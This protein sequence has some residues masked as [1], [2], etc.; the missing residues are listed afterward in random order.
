MPFTPYHFGPALL[1]GV[2]LIRFL[3]FSTIM[4]ASVILD[5]EPLTVL[6]LNLP[7]P[8]HG[9]FHT[10]LG[11]TIIAVVLAVS[12]WPLRNY[13]NTIMSFFGIHQE[14]NLRTIFLASISGTCSHVFLDSFLYVEMNPFYPLFGNP[15]LNLV[16]SQF[17][18]DLCVFAGSLGLVAYVVYVLYR[19]FK[20]KVA[21]EQQ[22]LF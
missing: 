4:I 13:L 5:L 8:L 11:A 7:L 1:I 18:Y 19:H 15:F 3:D 16:S 17:I 2:L 21:R 9:F 6:M 14:S 12:L 20:P 22:S 10:Y